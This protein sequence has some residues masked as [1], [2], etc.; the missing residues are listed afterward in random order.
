MLRPKGHNLTLFTRLTGRSAF[1]TMPATNTRRKYFPDPGFLDFNGLEREKTL[2]LIIDQSMLSTRQVLLKFVFMKQQQGI[3]NE[4]NEW[5]QKKRQVRR[6]SAWK[7]ISFNYV[8]SKKSVSLFFTLG[9]CFNNNTDLTWEWS[10]TGNCLM[11]SIIF[12][13]SYINVPLKVDH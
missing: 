8:N 12:L 5:E 11:I 6:P 3:P 13:S 7:E 1:E 10:V 9:I 4:P 2:S